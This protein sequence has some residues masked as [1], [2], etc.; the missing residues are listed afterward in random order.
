MH[1]E[2]E[3]SKEFQAELRKPVSWDGSVNIVTGYWLYGQI[4]MQF[5]SYHRQEIFILLKSIQSFGL[6]Y[7]VIGQV[8][9]SIL[10]ECSTFISRV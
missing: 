5:D 10:K 6:S 1:E 3:K 7:C 2:Y 4:N 9:S 8:F